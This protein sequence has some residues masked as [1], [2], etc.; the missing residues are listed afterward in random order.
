MVIF[1]QPPLRGCVLKQQR[2]DFLKQINMAAASARLCV[3]TPIGLLV[4]AFVAAA[5]SARLCV[6]TANP[7]NTITSPFAAASARLC[8]ETVIRVDGN[9]SRW[10]AAAS[11]RLCVETCLI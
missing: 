7:P 1:S 8:V 4:A 11:A 10:G 3:E 9:P 5:A 6:E 2:S